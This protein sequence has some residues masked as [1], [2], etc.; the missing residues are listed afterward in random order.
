MKPEYDPNHEEEMTPVE[1][2]FYAGLSLLESTSTSVREDRNYATSFVNYI[3][4]YLASGSVVLVEKSFEQPGI[5]KTVG[6]AKLGLNSPSDDSQAELV[7]RIPFVR[8]GF[9]PTH[10]N[11]TGKT[12][13]KQALYI[14]PRIISEDDDEK[15]QADIILALATGI[16]FTDDRA[17]ERYNEIAKIALYYVTAWHQNLL[18]ED[19]KIQNAAAIIEQ[20]YKIKS[21]QFVLNYFGARREFGCSFKD[22]MTKLDEKYGDNSLELKILEKSKFG[23]IIARELAA[24]YIGPISETDEEERYK[25][26]AERLI[27]YFIQVMK[28]LYHNYP[29]KLN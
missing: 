18:F 23:F 28:G 5:N 22:L 14:D 26:S 12:I 25:I 13:I 4:T 11:L 8:F 15:L 17:Y 6:D 2:R 3:K 16:Q 7:E 24:K 29:T 19:V 21:K 9:E 20:I 1:R 27:P 10:D